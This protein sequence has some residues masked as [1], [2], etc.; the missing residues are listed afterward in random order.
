MG[1]RNNS[2]TLKGEGVMRLDAI[3]LAAEPVDLE[4]LQK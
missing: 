1:F 3:L 2:G 4:S